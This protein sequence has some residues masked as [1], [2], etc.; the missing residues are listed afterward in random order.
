MIRWALGCAALVVGR[1]CGRRARM[2]CRRAARRFGRRELVR[3][4]EGSPLRGEEGERAGEGEPA[5]K[6]GPFAA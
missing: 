6:F 2:R 3:E 1:G 4:A 5:C